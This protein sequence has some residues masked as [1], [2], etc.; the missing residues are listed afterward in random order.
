MY[1]GEFKPKNSTTGRKA[2]NDMKA[3]ASAATARNKINQKDTTMT[4]DGMIN[5]S[6]Q[7]AGADRCAYN[8]HTGQRNDD[9]GHNQT[10]MPNR[11]GNLTGKTANGGTAQSM[12]LGHTAMPVKKPANPDQMQVG[13]MPNRVGNKG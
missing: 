7:R 13:Q 4:F 2:G 3:N 12:I 8:Q 11:K 5:G 10:Q 9:Q 6:S 1:S